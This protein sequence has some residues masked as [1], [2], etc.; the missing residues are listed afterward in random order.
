MNLIGKLGQHHITTQ[1]AEHVIAITIE[2][3]DNV[4]EQVKTYSVPVSGMV[5][6]YVQF[7]LGNAPAPDWWAHS[8]TVPES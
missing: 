3:T 7:Q 1:Q 4:G 6:P 2:N 5:E 8:S